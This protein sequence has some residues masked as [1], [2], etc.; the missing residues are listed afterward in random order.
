MKIFIFAKQII[1]LKNILK[2]K[3]KKKSIIVL[4]KCDKIQLERNINI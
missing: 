3:G 2:N 1:L 4:Y